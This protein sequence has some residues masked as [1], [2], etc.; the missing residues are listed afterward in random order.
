MSKEAAHRAWR[1]ADTVKRLSDRIIGLGPFGIGLDGILAWVPGANLVYGVGAGL[2]LLAEGIQAKA[3]SGTM[4]RM[5]AYILADNFSDLIPIP[6]AGSI[7]DMMFPGHL[8]AANA[9]Q[10]DIEDRHGAPEGVPKKKW[11]RKKGGKLAEMAA[12]H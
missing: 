2:M 9:L 3:S 4:T 10:K 12:R 8:M 11:Q 5:L 6:F 1:S 7:V